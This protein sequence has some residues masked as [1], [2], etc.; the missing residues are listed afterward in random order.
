MAWRYFTVQ[1]SVAGAPVLTNVVPTEAASMEATLS[2]AP[3]RRDYSLLGRDAKRAVET[4]L[5]AAEWYHTDVPR[6]QMKELMKREDGPA[7]RDTIIWLGALVLR[8]WAAPGSGARGG[9][10]RSSSS[11][12][13]STALPPIHAGTNAVTAPRSGRSG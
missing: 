2:V 13:S 6:K 12:A 4:G 7:I 5:A 11:M 10:C 3:S 8:V 9:A 1:A